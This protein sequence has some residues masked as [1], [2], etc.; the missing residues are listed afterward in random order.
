MLGDERVGGGPMLAQC[1]R[2]AGFVRL[3]QPRIAGYIGGEDRGKTAGLAHAALPAA[4]RRPDRKSSRSPGLR[5]GTSFGTTRGVMARNWP[6][7]APS[8]NARDRVL[9]AGR[10]VI[11]SLSYGPSAYC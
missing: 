9:G 5:K 2:R 10:I 11:P 1:P 3:H 4:R 6:T 8:R 7:I